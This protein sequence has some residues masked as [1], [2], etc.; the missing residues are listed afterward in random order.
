MTAAVALFNTVAPRDSLNFWKGDV[1]DCVKV[2]DFIGFDRKDIARISG[3][4][5]SSVRYDDRAPQEV[6]DH[7]AMIANICNLV[8]GFFND[9]V[10]TKLWLKAPNPM[11]GNAKPIDMIRLGRYDKLL[12]FVQDAIED[13]SATRAAKKTKKA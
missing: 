6:I 11:L 1:L 4:A 7:M 9:D 2:R 5:T 8:F 10:K 13:G 3:I 12:R